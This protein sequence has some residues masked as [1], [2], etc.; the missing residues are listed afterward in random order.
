MKEIGDCYEESNDYDGDLGAVCHEAET[1]ITEMVKAGLS[2]DLLKVL[3]SEIGELIK[4]NNY[5]NYWL[6]DLYQLLILVSSQT[7][8]YDTAIQILDNTL[9]K[10]PNSFRTDSLVKSKIELLEKAGKKA[11]KK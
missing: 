6:A 1:L 7:S 11:I 3:T 9:S 10:E 5:D 4:N 8:D 2:E